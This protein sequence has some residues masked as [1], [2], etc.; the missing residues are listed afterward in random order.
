MQTPGGGLHIDGWSSRLSGYYAGRAYANS[1]QLDG[2]GL[3]YDPD[4]KFRPT[5][6]LSARAQGPRLIE[7]LFNVPVAVPLQADLKSFP[8]PRAGR[9]ALSYALC[10]AVL[11]NHTPLGAR[12]WR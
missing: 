1:L 10:R 4:R 11:P 8:H 6:M 9:R 3:Y 12:E 2:G 5:E 7:A